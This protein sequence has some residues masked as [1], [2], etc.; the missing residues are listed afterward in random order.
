[1]QLN[2][3]GFVPLS[4]ADW[5]GRLAA[6]V[7]CQ[8]CPWRCGYCHNP[9]LQ[10]ARGE[11][12]ADWR[13]IVARLERRRGLIDAVVF[14]GGEPTAQGALL[15]AIQEMRDM[16][17][18]VGL[19]TAGMYPRRLKRLLPYIE[20]IGFDV[21]TVFADYATVTGSDGGALSVINSLQAVVDSGV[22][23]EFRTTVH[24]H[25]IPPHSL[26]SLAQAL[27]DLGVGRYVLQ[28][29]RNE[30]CGDARLRATPAS[31]YLDD[32]FCSRVAG[33]FDSLEV[34]RA[35]GDSLTWVKKKSRRCPVHATP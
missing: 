6:V 20:W 5:P 35:G 15:H 7:F 16:G 27:A 22:D 14:S 21:K 26:M 28:E 18:G 10:P 11:V 1:M 2:V 12:S 30:G 32:G 8:G 3:G 13:S 23:C 34:R 9:H 19:H 17:F 25:L 33:L 31:S 29:F 24:P 4:T